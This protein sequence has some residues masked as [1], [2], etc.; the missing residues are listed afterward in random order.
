VHESDVKN[1]LVLAKIPMALS[2]Q[3]GN[4]DMETKYKILKF[5]QQDNLKFGKIWMMLMVTKLLDSV[6]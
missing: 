2:V 5:D 4:K 6:G 3:G 1:C